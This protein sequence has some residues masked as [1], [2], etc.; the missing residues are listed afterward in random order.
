MDPF[1]IVG[2]TQSIGRRFSFYIAVQVVSVLAPGVVVIVGV[3]LLVELFHHRQSSQAAQSLLKGV[4]GATGLLIALFVL[5]AGYV[6]GYVIRELAFKLLTQLERLP[7]FRDELQ[8]NAYKRVESFFPAQLI[9]DCFETHPLLRAARKKE[10]GDDKTSQH[11]YGT[12]SRDNVNSEGQLDKAGG[13]HV[14]NS[15][16]RSFVYAKLWIRNF[17]PGFSIDNVEAEINILA[18][19]LAPGLL[20]GL[21]ILAAAHLTWWSVCAAILVVAL[22]WTVLLGSLLRLRRT[23]AYE[24]IRNLILDYTMRQA[25]N[26]YPSTQT[27]SGDQA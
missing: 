2:S 23:E 18:S 9:D 6:A 17:A 5:A 16:Y 1:S 20:T 15:N 27:T 3:F 25:I 14:E 7:R 13:G 26:G 11:N 24:A 10:S 12:S 4:S 22:I 19:G 8:V 21:V